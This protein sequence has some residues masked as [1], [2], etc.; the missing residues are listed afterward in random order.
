MIALAHPRAWLVQSNTWALPSS[1]APLRPEIH[2]AAKPARVTNVNP[3][4]YWKLR[5]IQTGIKNGA[6]VG[7][8]VES[9]TLSACALGWGRSGVCSDWIN[10]V[11]GA[12]V[13]GD[14]VDVST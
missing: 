8:G 6:V 4:M 1:S 10:G 3:P 13:S 9:V 12:N 11:G 2:Q 14:V 7:S 5:D